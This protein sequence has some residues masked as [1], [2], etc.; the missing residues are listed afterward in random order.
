MQHPGVHVPACKEVH[1]FSKNWHHSKAWYYDHFKEAQPDQCCGEITPFYLFH[2]DVPKRI[3]SLLPRVKLLVLLRDP[4]ERA[5][6]QVFHARK[7]GFEPLMPAE[8]IAAEPERLAGGDP[9]SFQKHSYLARSNYLEQMDRYESLFPPMQL[10]V[11]QSEAFFND[12]EPTWHQLQT[13]LGLE[14]IPIPET[15]PRA[16]AGEA[17]AQKVDSALRTHLRELLGTTAVR[18]RERYGFGWD[19]AT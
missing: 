14:Q 3:H 11:M 8:A 4:V 17:D 6:S 19:W 1:Y 15:M 10:L 5:L 2:P 12:P 13:F 16:N 18:V 7:R 9:E